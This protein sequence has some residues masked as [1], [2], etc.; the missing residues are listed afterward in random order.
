V[1]GD[2]AQALQRQQKAIDLVK[3]DETKQR[4]LARV[5]LF[6]QGKP[7]RLDPKDSSLS[8][9]ASPPSRRGSRRVED[10]VDR[11]DIL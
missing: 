11:Y 2:F 1:K 7:F 6:K 4:Y 10:C 9:Q 3:S 8:R 5:E